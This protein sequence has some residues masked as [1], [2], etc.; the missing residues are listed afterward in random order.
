VWIVFG[1]KPV[2][3]AG[4]KGNMI[5]SFAGMLLYFTAG[6][7]TFFVVFDRAILHMWEGLLKKI[8]GYTAMVV[9]MLGP[10]T[11]GWIAGLNFW[12]CIPAGLL[13]VFLAGE[14]TRRHLR[15]RYRKTLPDQAITIKP[16]AHRFVTTDALIARQYQISTTKNLSNPLRIIQLT[17]LHVNGKPPLPFYEEA[18]AAVE[19]LEPDLILFTGDY[20]NKREFIPQLEWIFSLS[21]ARLGAYAIMGNHEFYEDPEAVRTIIGNAGVRVIS[22][23][24]VDVTTDNT[25]LTLWG[26]EAPWGIPADLERLS[27]E[28]DRINIV[29]THTPDNIFELSRKG[30]DVVF[31]GHFHGGQW[32]VP[33]LGSL[34]IPSYHGRLLDHGRFQIGSTHLLVS[35][36]LGNVWF[37]CRIHCEPEI[38]VL[39]IVPSRTAGT[40]PDVDKV[41]ASAGVVTGSPVIP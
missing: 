28:T 3:G 27:R 23:E 31:A 7:F 2:E 5:E 40:A 6:V 25:H 21:N 20:I 10:A 17:D 39:D 1:F 9:F 14:V 37:P 41:C 29:L 24:R 34:V 13:T 15:N 38:V 8:T 16:R 26:H 32:R 35:A 19:R 30:A 12:A 22:G 18:M 33:V 11:A 36:G 4:Y